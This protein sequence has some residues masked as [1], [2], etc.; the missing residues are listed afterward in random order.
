MQCKKCGYERKESDIAPDYECP[1]CGAIYAKV[2]ARI[3][4]E[5][6][7]LK[8]KVEQ[9]AEELRRKIEQ[10]EQE[11]LNK[12][13]RQSNP[14]KANAVKEKLIIKT[15]TGSQEKAFADFQADALKM[16]NEGYYPSTQTWVPG[17]YGCGSF[18]GALLLCFLIVGFLIFIYM[19]IVKPDGTLSVT[20][21]LR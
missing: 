9:G 5:A 20:Y 6:E 3:K 8:L 13:L 7:E 11:Q 18:L 10:E 4:K 14:Q 19:L 15:Y 21:E 17:S 1:N 16:A 12:Q 2:E